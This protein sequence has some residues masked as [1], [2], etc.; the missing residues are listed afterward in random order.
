MNKL[1]FSDTT[2]RVVSITVV[3]VTGLELELTIELPSPSEWANDLLSLELPEVPERD[4][5]KNGAK[6]KERDFSD[7]EYVRKR[8]Y[9]FE[10]LAMRR[11]ARAL[12]GGGNLED[13]ADL[14][15]DALT[16]K[17]L[18][19]GDKSLYQG[20]YRAILEIMEGT[21]GG[22]AA[23]KASFRPDTLPTN[24]DADLPS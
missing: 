17:I 5:W 10:K 14:S 19:D 9:A 4:I 11:T 22:I 21:K 16:E 6:T 13:M 15:I 20:I 12:R 24:G 2:K 3:S 1:N 18:N 8:D 7:T 23:K